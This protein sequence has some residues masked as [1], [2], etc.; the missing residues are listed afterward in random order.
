MNFGM[1]LALLMIGAIF[2]V[3]I[4]VAVLVSLSS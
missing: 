1:I 2:A 4:G 3:P